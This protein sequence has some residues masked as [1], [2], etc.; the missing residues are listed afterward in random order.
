MVLPAL[1]SESVEPSSRFSNSEVCMTDP[2]LRPQC[3]EAV[4]PKRTKLRSE[5]LEPNLNI[6]SNENLLPQPAGPLLFLTDMLLPMY[7]ASRIEILFSD[8]VWS[9]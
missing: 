1:L 5:T 9:P 6:F 2:I 3:T 4:D 7:I 8:L